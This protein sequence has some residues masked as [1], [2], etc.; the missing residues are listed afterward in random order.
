TLKE[1]TTQPLPPFKLPGCFPYTSRMTITT[2][3]TI[4]TNNRLFRTIS[5][6]TQSS[7]PRTTLMTNSVDTADSW[8]FEIPW[9]HRMA[10]DTTDSRTARAPPSWSSNSCGCFAVM[11]AMADFP[12]VS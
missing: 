10:V 4:A 6:N 12:A 2:P 11:F 9:D 5:E 1:H 7:T 8:A 3:A